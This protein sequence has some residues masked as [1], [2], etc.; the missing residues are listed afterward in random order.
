MTDTLTASPTVAATAPHRTRVDLALL[1]LALGG[2]AIGTTEFVTLGLLPEV[3]SGTATDIPTAGHFVS[4][5]AVGVVVGPPLIALL[6][7]RLPRKTVLVALM[8]WF[9]VANAASGFA[10]D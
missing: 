7:A 10:S 1:A 3:A 2:F 6:A 8:T 4:A 9:S 5:Y